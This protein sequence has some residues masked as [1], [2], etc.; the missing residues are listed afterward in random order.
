MSKKIVSILLALMIMVG[1]I[2][3]GYCDVNKKLSKAEVEKMIEEVARK[4]GIPSVI[5]K[6]IAKAESSL[7]QFNTDGSVVASRGGNLGIMQ[8]HRSSGYNEKK[9][10]EDPIYNIESG[11]DLLLS[12]WRYAN[13][14]M[15]QIGD[16]DPNVLENWYFALWAYNGLLERNN[17]NVRENTYQSKIYSI[18]NKDYG[19]KITPISRGSIQSR[20]VPKKGGKIKSPDTIHKG[21][22]IT[23]NVGDVVVPDGK[24]FLVL[25][26][27]PYGKEIGK[28]KQNTSMTILEGPKL[29]KGFYFYKV[30]T[31][32]NK[33]GWIFGNWLKLKEE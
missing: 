17:P 22:I 2:S 27:T 1:I 10:K 18:A 14:R 19:Q 13:S 24:K 23:Y 3:V 16:M 12:K 25:Q 5:L 20:G 9:L 7:K 21:D 29:K 31:Q 30:K 8:V 15:P 6:S 32:D 33:T 4:R 26:N 28:V 11:A